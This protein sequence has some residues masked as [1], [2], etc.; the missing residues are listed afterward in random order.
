[1]RLEAYVT[2]TL[3]GISA[4]AVAGIAA[5]VIFAILPGHGP[6]GVNQDTRARRRRP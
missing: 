1:M 6:V 2:V 4:L 5:M 3:A